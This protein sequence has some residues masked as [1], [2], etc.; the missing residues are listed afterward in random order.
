LREAE[1]VA[2]WQKA[3]GYG[4]RGREFVG[5]GEESGG[6]AFADFKIPVC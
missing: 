6:V 2:G 4:R 1:F 5:F 3:V